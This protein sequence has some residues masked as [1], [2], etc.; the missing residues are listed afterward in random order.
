CLRVFSAR[1]FLNFAALLAKL[2][3]WTRLFFIGYFELLGATTGLTKV[4]VSEYYF[5]NKF[6]AERHTLFC[7]APSIFHVNQIKVSEQLPFI[8][9]RFTIFCAI[10]NSDFGVI[11]VSNRLFKT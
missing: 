9:F 10:V 11:A 1:W 5:G 6:K 7:N 2:K 3:S 8:E 4:N